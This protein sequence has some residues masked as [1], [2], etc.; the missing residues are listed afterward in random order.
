M[1]VNKTPAH[2]GQLSSTPVRKRLTLASPG[3]IHSKAILS[4]RSHS[5]SL[6]LKSY[7]VVLKE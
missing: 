6:P 4:Q 3:Q 2:H 7:G 5:L 1:S